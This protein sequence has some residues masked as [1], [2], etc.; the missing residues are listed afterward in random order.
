MKSPCT[1]R[2]AMSTAMLCVSAQAALAAATTAPPERTMGAMA[3]RSAS[4]PK[5]RLATAMPSTTAETVSEA[6]PALTPNWSRSTGSPRLRDVDGEERPAYQRE[7]H[8]L[9][10]SHQ[11]GLLSRKRSTMKRFSSRA[12]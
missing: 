10:P 1:N 6:V 8:G 12:P 11:E 3:N 4:T 5:G 9:D 7:H 2:A